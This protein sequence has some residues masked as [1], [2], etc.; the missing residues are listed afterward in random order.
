VLKEI[1]IIENMVTFKKGLTR[2]FKDRKVVSGNLR[3]LMEK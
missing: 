1:V 2:K 3:S